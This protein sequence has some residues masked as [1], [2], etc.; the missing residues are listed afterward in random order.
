MERNMPALFEVTLLSCHVLNENSRNQQNFVQ[1]SHTNK[2][3]TG[4][5]AIC[6]F[7]ELPLYQCSLSMLDESGA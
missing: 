3:L 2:I 4:Y 5:F 1:P 7:V 6:R